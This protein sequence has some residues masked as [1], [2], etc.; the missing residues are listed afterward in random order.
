MNNIKFFHNPS[1][2]NPVHALN[3]VESTATCTYTHTIGHELN[4]LEVIALIASCRHSRRSVDI[5]YIH[6]VYVHRES[7]PLWAHK[8]DLNCI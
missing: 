8:C 3:W 7:Y 1:S 5:E 6:F 4:S 2:S